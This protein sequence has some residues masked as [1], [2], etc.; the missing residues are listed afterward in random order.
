MDSSMRLAQIRNR[1]IASWNNTKSDTKQENKTYN[2]FRLYNILG[3]LPLYVNGILDNSVIATVTDTENYSL[4]KAVFLALADLF[5]YQA[6]Q[7][8]GPTHCSRLNYLWFASLAQAYN[9]V[10]NSGPIVG[11]KDAWN[12]N[13]RHPLNSD[14]DIFLWMNRFLLFLMPYFIPGYT[15][16]PLLQKEEEVIGPNVSRVAEVARIQE[17][18]HW[19]DFKTAWLAWWAFREMDG[20]LEAALPPSPS[21]NPNGTQ[22]LNVATDADDPNTFP[23]PERWTPLKL[24]PKTQKYL[25]YDW[26][27]VVSTGLSEADETAVEAAANAFYPDTA[28]RQSE[29]AEVVQI[30]AEL[31]DTEKITAEFWAG[32]PFTISPPGM[33]IWFWKQYMQTFNIAY[34]RGFD[35]FFYSVLDLAIHI[36]ETSRI[37]WGLKKTHMQARP[38]QEIR[39]WYRGQTLI[40]YNGQ[41]IAGELWVPYQEVDFV[42]PPFGDFPSGHSS[43]SESF[44]LVMTDWFG[45]T[46]PT[47]SPQ[48]I[49]DL[50]LLSPVFQTAQTNVFGVFVFPAKASLI[51]PG[52]VPA[53]PITLQWTSWQDMA[54]SA[55][56]S[57]KYGG[58][59]A[60]SAHTSSQ[61]LSQE[62]HTRLKN[63]W[64]S[65]A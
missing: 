56:L 14:T 13:T 46:I 58:I 52:I 53:S 44:A 27:S 10:R 33:C 47:S 37:T 36:F 39:R 1:T 60:T 51:Q 20:S 24:G 62:L 54:N 15:G 17:I 19:S 9:W 7:N 35:V 42:S 8:L 49:S 50:S 38:I 6:T 18:A 32:G 25:T 30:T 48:S 5:M 64:F 43:F 16:S 4:D 29:I 2:E 57:R 12:W 59:H 63:L 21:D 34:S 41:P 55:G 22:S 11:T 26:K 65:P 23:Y 3:N 45:P 31:T 28:T 40:G 61:A